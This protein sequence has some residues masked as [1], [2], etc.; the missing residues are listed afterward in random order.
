MKVSGAMSLL[1]GSGEDLLLQGP[2]AL[3][4]KAPNQQ[5]NSR[6][7]ASLSGERFTKEA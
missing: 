2:S 5:V 3:T 6:L 7:S 1:R 4:N